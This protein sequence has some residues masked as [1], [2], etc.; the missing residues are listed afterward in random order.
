[1]EQVLQE[2]LLC[3]QETVPL[4][5]EETQGGADELWFLR[6]QSLRIPIKTVH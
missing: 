4:S 2:E 6:T 3:V 1:M 5:A